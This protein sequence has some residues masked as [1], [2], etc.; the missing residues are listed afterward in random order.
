MKEFKIV[1]KRLTKVEYIDF[2]KRSDLGNQYPLERF[3]QRIEKL[4]NN[5]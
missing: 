5:C 1:S 2:L 3:D 4:V